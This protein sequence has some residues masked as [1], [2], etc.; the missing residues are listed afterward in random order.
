MSERGL[1]RG[2]TSVTVVEEAR[3]AI[4]EVAPEAAVAFRRILG[5]ARLRVR[6]DARV[7]PVHHELAHQ[8]DLHV[9]AAALRNRVDFLATFN[10]RDF[11]GYILRDH[12]GLAVIHPSI[13]LRA[14]GGLPD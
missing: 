12:Y 11:R 2:Y 3:R 13:L 10:I 8:G 6:K 9:V 4:A 14:L 1:I 5:R 7:R